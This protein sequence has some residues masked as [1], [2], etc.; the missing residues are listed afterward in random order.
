MPAPTRGYYDPPP[1]PPDHMAPLLPF[2]DLITYHL[3]WKQNQ[4]FGL[5]G[6]TEQGKTNLAYNLLDIY[7]TYVAYFAIKTKDP[8]LDAFVASGQYTRIYDWPPMKS[9]FLRS[10]RPYTA[11][12]MPRRLVWP[13]ATSLDS[14]AEQARVFS[15]A[16]RDIY[17]EGGWCPVFDDYWYLAHI[18]GFEK[19]TKKML[20][21]ARSNDIPMMICA[22]RPAGNRLVELFDQ[23]T[24]LCFFRDMDEPNLT[25]ISGVGATSARA[26]RGFVANLEMFQFLYVNT[27]TGKMYRSRAPKLEMGLAA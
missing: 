23:C 5:V 22:Q 27:R 26:I 2:D 14:E 6:P 18:L 16:L 20:A 19:D 24:H 1:P 8:T 9:R 15:K 25:R 7:R 4:H 10:G 11:E 17:V 12:E 21:N 3:N 13:D